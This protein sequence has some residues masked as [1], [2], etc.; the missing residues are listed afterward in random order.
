MYIFVQND[1]VLAVR[2]IMAFSVFRRRCRSRLGSD[3]WVVLAFF[4]VLFSVLLIVF[5]SRVMIWSFECLFIFLKFEAQMPSM[6]ESLNLRLNH[7]GLW[8]RLR[9]KIRTVP[10]TAHSREKSCWKGSCFRTSRY[11]FRFPVLSLTKSFC[12]WV[13]LK[14]RRLPA[15]WTIFSTGCAASFS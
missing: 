2:K 10:G 12:F 13:T 1:R 11:R 15:L 7:Q 6:I 5:E 8:S 14:K 9:Q 4:V 3:Q